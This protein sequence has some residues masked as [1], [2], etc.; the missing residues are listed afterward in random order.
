MRQ[1]SAGWIR[2]PEFVVAFT[3]LAS[4][5]SDNVIGPDNQLQVT[6]ATNDFQ[7]QVSNLKTVT[8]TLTYTWSNTGDSASVNQSSSISYGT[9]TLTIRDPTGTIL[10]KSSVANNGTYHTLKGTTG[11]WQLE[12][13]MNKVDGTFNFRVQKAP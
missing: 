1:R 11:S 12:V 2:I 5:S 4:C 3:I 6:N 9:A 10:Y 13:A 7:F 8:Q